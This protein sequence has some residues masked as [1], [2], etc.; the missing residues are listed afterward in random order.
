M[1]AGRGGRLTFRRPPERVT[2]SRDASRCLRAGRTVRRKP[3]TPEWDATARPLHCITFAF[4][5]NISDTGYLR[6]ILEYFRRGVERTEA[7]D[8]LSRHLLHWALTTWEWSSSG[9]APV[10]SLPVWVDAGPALFL[11]TV[12]PARGPDL[13]WAFPASGRCGRPPT[14]ARRSISASG[15]DHARPAARGCGN[16][17]VRLPPHSTPIFPRLLTAFFG[18]SHGGLF[19][20]RIYILCSFF[21]LSLRFFPFPADRFLKYLYYNIMHANVL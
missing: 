6:L 21:A 17:T 20:R 16:G 10:C 11:G 15:V 18:Y 13:D 12:V 1:S 7:K 8:T 4:R 14:V 5:Y 2:I 3:C 19:S 9:S